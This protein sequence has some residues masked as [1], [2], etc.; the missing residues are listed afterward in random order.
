MDIS[1]ELLT[2]CNPIQQ[3]IADFD[4]HT[5]VNLLVESI[6]HELIQFAETLIVAVIQPLLVSQKFLTQ[7]KATAAVTGISAFV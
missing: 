7:L 5:D 1:S 3:A 6:R 2:R 4:K